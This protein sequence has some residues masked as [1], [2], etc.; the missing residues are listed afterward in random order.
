MNVMLMSDRLMAP[1]CAC[2][3]TAASVPQRPVAG[4]WLLSVLVRSQQPQCFSG[5]WQAHGC[6][7]C[8]S[9]DSSLSAS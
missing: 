1:V 9:G 2:E 3:V 5:Q 7:L 4:S 6:W 8:L